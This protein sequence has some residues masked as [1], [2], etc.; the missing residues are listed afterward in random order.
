PMAAETPTPGP[1]MAPMANARTAA[2]TPGTRAHS[3]MARSGEGLF[4][5]FSA[6]SHHDDV[7]AP[8]GPHDQAD[9]EKDVVGVRE[10]VDEEPDAAP[11]REAGQEGPDDG[12]RCPIAL[13]R[14]LTVAS[15]GH[16]Q[17]NSTW[18]APAAS[19]R[20]ACISAGGRHVLARL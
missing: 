11:D 3:A 6:I 7:H 16:E 19:K 2:G 9:G 13:P 14:V 15:S 10:P 8:D 4:L 17:G 1:T 5:S 18:G 12:P 20:E